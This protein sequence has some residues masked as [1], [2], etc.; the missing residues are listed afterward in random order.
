MMRVGFDGRA[1]QPGFREHQGRGIGVYAIEL[2]R[3]LARRG[4]VE[5][6]LWHQ[7]ELPLPEAHVPDGVATRAYPRLGLPARDRLATQLT[8]PAVLASS[9]HDVFHFPAHGDAPAG[10]GRGV[11]VTVHDL[12]LEVMARD[13]DPRG[14]IPFRIARALERSAVRRA[15]AVVTDSAV[16]RDDV[17][18]R[19]AVSSERVHVAHLGLHPRIARPDVTVIAATLDRLELRRPYVLYLGGIDARKDVPTLLA[20][21]TRARSIPTEPMDLVI[22]G[23]VR[24]ARGFPALLERARELGIESTLRLPGHIADDDLPALHAGARVFAF[25]SRYEGFGFPP[26]EAMACGTPVL[27]SGGGSLQE[28]LGDAALVTPPGDVEAFTAGLS[29]LLGDE[30]LRRDLAARGPAHAARFTWERTAEATVAAYRQVA[31][32]GAAR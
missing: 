29:R 31:G 2:V 27:S 30:A 9:R 15:Q 16:T 5:L 8:V 18:G 21:W 24:E 3:A 1:L 12:I 23:R 20:A 6:T 32:R 14:S 25:P 11:V 10:G 7:P 4:D 22:A 19:Y 26:L 17:V 28:V 13:Y